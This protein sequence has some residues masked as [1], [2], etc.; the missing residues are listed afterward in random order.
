MKPTFA[1][2]VFP[3]ALPKL[4]TYSVPET[5]MDSIQVGIRVEVS[6]KN[7]SYAAIVVSLHN[8]VNES[9]KPKPIISILDKLPLISD[10]M[11]DF[12]KWIAQYYCCTLGRSYGCQFTCGHETFK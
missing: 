7:K 2:V 9:Y 6:L 8:E 3:L 11:L 4:Y 1:T 10:L 5:F 12:W